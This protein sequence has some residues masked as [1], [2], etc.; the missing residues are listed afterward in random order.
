MNN[1]NNIQAVLF[2][3]SKYGYSDCVKWL[4]LHGFLHFRSYRITSLF[5]RSRLIEPDENKYN[6]RIEHLGDSGIRYIFQYQK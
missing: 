5:Y 1:K 4:L 6:Y 3:K 2:D